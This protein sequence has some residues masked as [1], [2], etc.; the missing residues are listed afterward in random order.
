MTPE[1]VERPGERALIKQYYEINSPSEAVVRDTPRD[2]FQEWL[3]ATVRWHPR[4][5]EVSPVYRERIEQLV[6]D[7]PSAEILTTDSVPTLMRRYGWTRWQTLGTLTAL[8]EFGIAYSHSQYDDFKHGGKHQVGSLYTFVQGELQ[9]TP[10][11]KRKVSSAR[12]QGAK[13]AARTRRGRAA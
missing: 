11:P 3:L 12:R 5:E 10:Q 6:A 4:W 2:E 13:R 1:K 9:G 7:A 8:R